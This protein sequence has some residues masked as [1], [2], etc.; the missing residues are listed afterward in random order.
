MKIVEVVARIGDS[1]ITQVHLEPD[2]RFVIGSEPGCDLAVPGIGRFPLVDG[3]LVRIP[4]GVRANV[5]GA[6]RLGDDTVEVELGLA[7]VSIRKLAR[8]HVPVPRP[9]RDLRMPAFLIA[10]LIAQVALWAAAAIIAPYTDPPKKQRLLP[11]HL[12]HPAPPKA[13]EKVPEPPPP[14]K[15]QARVQ[16]APKGNTER[17]R[18][19]QRHSSASQEAT[20]DGFVALAKF[21]KNWKDP[22]VT[23]DG[24]GTGPDS[25][26][27][28]YYGHTRRFDPES[29]PAYDSV[30]VTGFVTPTAGKAL[31][32]T[33]PAPRLEFCDDDSCLANGALPLATFIAELEKHRKQIQDCY[34][35]HTDSA[36]G[37]IRLRFGVTRDGKPFSLGVANVKAVPTTVLGTGIGTVGR[38]VAKILDN[39]KWPKAKEETAVWIGI[40][41]IPPPP[42]SQEPASP[43]P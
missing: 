10:S 42:T 29:D 39:V 28:Y 13:P 4:A 38:C 43:S 11:V 16:T 1:T 22:V 8:P 18:L 31:G 19:R 32:Q 35:D 27:D 25:Y 5:D 21:A 40:A 17:P 36:E 2:G 15:P 37:N 30:K 3:D 33:L 14:P 20:E 26:E 41:F 6:V 7:R 24:T 12:A 34:V 23:L 9:P